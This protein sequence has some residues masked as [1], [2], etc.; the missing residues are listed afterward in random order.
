M[1]EV[2]QLEYGVVYRIEIKMGC[3]YIGIGVIGRALYGCKF[4][5]FILVRHNNHAAGMLPGRALY[6][7]AAL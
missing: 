1:S 7:G 6:P 3:Y 2:V 5:D 4:L